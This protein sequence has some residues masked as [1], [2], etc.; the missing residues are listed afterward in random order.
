MSIG[1]V[2][3]LLPF[4]LAAEAPP[5]FDVASVKPAAKITTD[6]YNINLGKTSHGELT[7]GNVTLA[8]CL[9]FAYGL[10]D[11]VQL[12]GP[13]WI[14][15]KGEYIYDVVAKA[16]PDTPRERLQQMLQTLLTERFQLVLHREQRQESYAA[17][18]QSKKGIKLEPADP[19]LP[20]SVANTF[21]MGHIDTKGVYM[22]MLATVLSRFMRQPVLDMTG[23]PGRYVVKLDWTP[24]PVEP[25]A[26]GTPAPGASPSIFTALQE[27]LGLKLESRKGPLEVIVV[28]HAERVPIAN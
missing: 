15:R 27:Q 18:V 6:S 23:L 3:F 11:N 9:K 28:D 8:E 7:M 5:A 22:P 16:A 26:P 24:D 25:I 12:D 14:K 4:M 13:D 2:V 1:W 21:H 19:N 10:T 20:G 17:L